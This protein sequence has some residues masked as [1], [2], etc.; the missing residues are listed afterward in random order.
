MPTYL[1]LIS[2]QAVAVTL[3]IRKSHSRYLRVVAGKGWR[4]A[5]A[6]AVAVAKEV[7][8]GEYSGSVPPYPCVWIHVC[9]RTDR[10]SETFQRAV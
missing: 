2:W 10:L 7:V 4:V 5:V 1:T 8:T 3:R 6:V 9:G